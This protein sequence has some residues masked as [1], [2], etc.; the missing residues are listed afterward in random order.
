[1]TLTTPVAR[2]RTAA[3]ATRAVACS[4]ATLMLAGCGMFDW[5]G[6]GGEDTKPKL[7]GNRISVLQFDQRAEPDP[8]LV[9]REVALPEAVANPEWAQPGGNP[10]HS[11]GHLA[12]GDSLHQVW[13][14]SIEGSSSNDRLLGAPV[15]AGGRVYVL[16]TDYDLHAFDERS[17]KQLWKVNVKRKDQ[18]GDAI[19]GAVSFA[20]GKLFATTGF[21]EVVAVDPA[22]GANLWRQR[23]A[24]PIRSGAT[25]AG[26]RVFVVTVDNQ[27]IVLGAEDRV[28]QWTQTGI[29]EPTAMLGGSS[30]AVDND[31]AVVPYSSGELYALR[32]E[33]GREAW[34][35]SL[36][37]LRRGTNLTG[38]SDIR[39]LPVI[40]R[41]TVFAVSYS[42]R[43]AAVDLRTG[44]RLWE[45][46]LGGI[47]TPWVAGD[48]LFLVTNDSQLVAM[49]R[50][51]GR[52]RWLAELPKYGDPKD[53]SDPIIWTGPLLAGGRLIL[54][55]NLGELVECS[56]QDG[57][58][59]R[60]TELPGPVKVAPVIANS[61]LFVL[62]DDGDL[63]AYR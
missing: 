11:M 37:A 25:I 34:L 59:L 1:M 19:G 61:T 51:G 30:A 3:V 62:T 38:L 33:N 45:Q 31:I 29:L 50:D 44:Q 36:S 13:R 14:S 52:V 54:A 17:G 21:G 5:L 8:T 39:G 47:E 28:L 9:G 23:I 49:T 20:D 56:V 41:G 32:V 58:I 10:T 35:D 63:V 60:K 22:T 46:D 6:I 15:V 53:K 24:G 16:D 7:P 42:G 43:T 2:P 55:N 27:F 4:L 57:H 40:D 48:W 12:L 18:E 26:G